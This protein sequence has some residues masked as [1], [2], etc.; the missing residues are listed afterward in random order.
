M[1]STQINAQCP[2]ARLSFD[3]GKKRYFQAPSCKLFP[4]WDTGS[5]NGGW[6]QAF[7]TIQLWPE[8]D[9][10]LP[11]SRKKPWSI[12][13][14][15][16]NCDIFPSRS[17]TTRERPA[18]DTR[19]LKD[20]SPSGINMGIRLNA[21]RVLTNIVNNDI[22]S[23]KDKN[24]KPSYRDCSEFQVLDGVAPLHKIPS[25]E[26]AYDGFSTESDEGIFS[27]QCFGDIDQILCLM[28]NAN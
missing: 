4:T 25:E 8:L 6:D 27:D 15:L 3:E 16:L 13:S 18:D 28:A 5:D 23:E 11:Q 7:E 12:V 24:S 17:T 20:C 26:A 21:S 14:P 9:P 19:R 10:H 1:S 22:R 2:S